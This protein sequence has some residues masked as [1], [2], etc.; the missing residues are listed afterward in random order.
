MTWCMEDSKLEHFRLK[1]HVLEKHNEY[2]YCSV[3]VFQVRT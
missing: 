2:I 3:V 1:G